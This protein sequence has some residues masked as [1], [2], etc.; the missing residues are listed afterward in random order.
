MYYLYFMF[1]IKVRVF[2]TSEIYHIICT[3][4]ICFLCLKSIASVAFHTCFWTMMIC[5]LQK[6]YFNYNKH[7]DIFFTLYTFWTSQ[8]LY[9]LRVCIE[10]FGLDTLNHMVRQ[11]K[12]KRKFLHKPFTSKFH[13]SG[14]PILNRPT[15]CKII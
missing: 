11:W 8:F 4:S 3:T 13:V 2:I 12:G 7:Y 1:R 14:W 9:L 6:K 5:Q 15:S 10:K